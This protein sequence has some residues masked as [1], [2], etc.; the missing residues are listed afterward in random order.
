M[1]IK[2]CPEIIQN[3]QMVRHHA[4]LKTDPIT[5]VYVQLYSFIY[6]EEEKILSLE[7]GIH[8]V[9]SQWLFLKLRQGASMGHFCWLVG[10]MVGWFF[11]GKKSGKMWKQT[12]AM[13]FKL[14]NKGD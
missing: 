4:V 2:I 7:F 8:G 11:V 3:Y 5:L 6:N 9:N 12:A 10:W 14:E 1:I 13:R